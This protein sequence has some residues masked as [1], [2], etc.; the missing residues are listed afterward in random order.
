M[1][2]Q[3]R[4][5]YDAAKPQFT[6]LQYAKC[7]KLC[8]IRITGIRRTLIDHHF[9]PP[10]ISVTFGI[11]LNS[12]GQPVISNSSILYLRAGKYIAKCRYTYTDLRLKIIVSDTVR[13]HRILAISKS[14]G[15]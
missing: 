15:R 12:T 9:L 4:I 13:N 3:D 1:C 2:E 14:F 5:V 10:V 6:G 11:M 7:Y 8:T